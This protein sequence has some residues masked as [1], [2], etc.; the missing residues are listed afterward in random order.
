MRAYVSD[1]MLLTSLRVL[2]TV[3]TWNRNYDACII[4][5]GAWNTAIPDQDINAGLKFIGMHHTIGL[6]FDD[7]LPVYEANVVVGGDR[8]NSNPIL[9]TPMKRALI[10]REI[11]RNYDWEFNLGHGRV[12]ANL[13][14]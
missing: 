6:G 10:G 14:P 2:S 12:L 11:I 5:T 1:G 7:D 3:N 13:N 9:G 8:F 4:D